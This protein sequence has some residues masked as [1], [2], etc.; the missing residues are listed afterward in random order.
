M[1]RLT[2]LVICVVLV[3]IGAFRTPGHADPSPLS[4]PSASA[5]PATSQST[6]S[7]PQTTPSPA[8]ETKLKTIVVTATRVAQPIDEIGTT[9]TVVPD[10][11]M[12]SQK[13]QSVGTAL[14]QVPGVTVTQ[15][16]SPG[17]ES[18]VSIRGASASQSLILI[19]GVE[20]NSG[21]TGA[22]D[23]GNLTTQ[24]LNRIEVLRGAGGSLYGSQAIGGVVNILSQEGEGPPA[25]TLL[26]QGGN[27]A[28]QRQ[29]ATVSGAQGKLGFSGSVDYFSTEGFHLVNDNSDNLSLQGRLDYHP[30]DD[31]TV[32]GFAR[33]IM[34]NVSLTNF[35]IPFG[36]PNNPTAHQRGEFMLYKGEVEHKFGERLVV[37]ANGYYVRNQIRLN[38]TPFLGFDGSE[39][40]NIPEESRGA[41]IE[42]VYT[43]NENFRT[44]SGFDFRSL[45]ARSDST[46]V[47]AGTLSASNFTASQQQYA[48]YL[49]QQ[50]TFLNG[51][52]LA[53]GGFRVD[54]NSQFGTEVSPSWSVLIP[55]AQL[56]TRLRGSYSEGFRAPSFDELYFPGFG[57]PN[58]KPE[59]SSEYDGGFTTNFGE[60]ASL[61]ATYF[62]RRVHDLIVTVPCP[63][64][65]GCQF[66]AMAGNAGR[67]DTQGVEI[68]PSIT[69]Y[70]GLNLSGSVTYLDETHVSASGATPTRVP[71]WSAQSLLQYIGNGML[72]AHDQV[73]GSFAMTFVGDRDD[74]TPV[75]TIQNHDAYYRFDL[76]ASYALGRRWN[77]LQDEQVF[78]RISNLFDRTYSEAFGFRSPPINFVAGVKLDLQ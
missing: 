29:I 77:Y 59:I 16:G 4:T 20:V 75:G 24:N 38:E 17:T 62:S 63:V 7:A 49:E 13:I 76:V 33:Y 45:W 52:L 65:P 26:S 1:N 41:Q 32:R 71:K 8:Q 42:A 5:T 43:W 78:T 58:L 19:D 6:Q 66:G 56:S 35:T 73:V 40:D 22:F 68:V 34:S 64:G 60:L 74:I 25:A 14:Q 50:G 30:T 10:R 23:I 27:S 39:V 28:T 69:L 72:F 36:V 44:V 48:G 54:G 57:N 51:H 37:R 70:K 55:I 18:D 61:T 9:V 47:F 46:S 31:T 2:F 21:T 3:C 67:V 11:Q 15:S 53:T 12:E